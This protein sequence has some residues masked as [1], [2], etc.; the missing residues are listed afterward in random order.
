MFD[1]AEKGFDGLEV[2]LTG[3]LV[4]EGGVRWVVVLEARLGVV[5]KEGEGFVW[6]LGFFEVC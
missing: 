3:E 2:S 1:A 4:D 6:V 5:L